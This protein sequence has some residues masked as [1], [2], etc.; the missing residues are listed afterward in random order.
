MKTE[1]K[2]FTIKQLVDAWQSAELRRPDEYQRGEDW[3]LPQK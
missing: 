1:K 2:P 3:S